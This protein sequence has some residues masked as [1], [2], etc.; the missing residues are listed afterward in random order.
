[1]PMSDIARQMEA[2]DLA[3]A[4]EVVQEIL[5]GWDL[6][7]WNVL[8]SDDVVLSV[9]FG[10]ADFCEI[11]DGATANGNFRVFGREDVKRV[12]DSIYPKLKRGLSVTTEIVSGYDVVLSGNLVVPSTKENTD[13]LSLPVVLYMAFDGEEQINRMTIAA[14][15]LH[16]LT[17]AIWMAVEGA[18]QT[19][20]IAEGGPGSRDINRPLS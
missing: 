10:A 18:D 19:V 4:R 12:L 1:M 2:K 8:L 13:A 5:R 11:G 6:L 14:L 20:L 3:H 17:G 15:D 9:R 16:L 7:P